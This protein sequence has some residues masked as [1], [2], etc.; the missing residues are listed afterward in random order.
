LHFP[1]ATDG[2]QGIRFVTAA[3]ASSNANGA[4]VSL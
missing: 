4:W 3:V 2:L 1:N